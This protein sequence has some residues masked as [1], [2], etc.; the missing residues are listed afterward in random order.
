MTG[1][2]LTC[3]K[4]ELLGFI[5]EL[6]KQLAQQRDAVKWTASDLNVARMRL[7]SRFPEVAQ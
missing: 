6:E 2:L 5:V 1:G 4:E 7:R 3:S